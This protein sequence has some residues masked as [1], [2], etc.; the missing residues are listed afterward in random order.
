MNRTSFSWMLHGIYRLYFRVH[1]PVQSN[2]F[3]ISELPASTIS[4]FSDVKRMAHADLKLFIFTQ[5]MY[6][7]SGFVS[8]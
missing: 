2:T 1:F 6:L 4:Q 5:V 7:G 8:E 3:A